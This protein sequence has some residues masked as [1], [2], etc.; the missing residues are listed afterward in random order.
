MEDLFV[1]TPPLDPL[2][3]LPM[4]VHR[5]GLKVTVVDVKRARMSGVVKQEGGNHRVQT[6]EGTRTRGTCWRL[7]VWLFEIRPAARSSGEDSAD[8]LGSLGM[9]RGKA[10]AAPLR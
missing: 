6:P 8:K 10:V 9:A 5:D 7:R 1:A 2:K 4:L 3:S